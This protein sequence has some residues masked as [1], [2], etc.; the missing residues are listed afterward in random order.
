VLDIASG[1]STLLYENSAYSEP[2]WI[3]D[4]EILFFKS[5][6]RGSTSL[7]LADA[8]KPGSE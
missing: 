3:T 1:D 4:R 8:S 2:V 5:G 7:M 6:E